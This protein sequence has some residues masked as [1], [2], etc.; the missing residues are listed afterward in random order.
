MRTDVADVRVGDRFAHN[1][2]RITVTAI[3]T[4]PVLVEY[5]ILDIGS[6]V[7]W[8]SKTGVIPDAWVK[9]GSE[10]AP[11][12]M[13][14]GCQQDD[15]EPGGIYCFSCVVEYADAWAGV[16]EEDA[17]RMARTLIDDAERERYAR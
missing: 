5:T 16:H 2:H 14:V 3:R 8:S 15:A 9:T 7:S 17:K 1:E 10:P 4:D 13:C 11:I 12:Q 6:K